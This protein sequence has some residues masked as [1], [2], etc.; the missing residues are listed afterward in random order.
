MVKKSKFRLFFTVILILVLVSNFYINSLIVRA[1][2]EDNSYLRNITGTPDIYEDDNS[3]SSSKN[4][5]LNSEQERSISSVDD[6]D[7]VNFTLDSFYS[8]EIETTGLLGDTRLWIFDSNYNQIGFDDDGGT[9]KF[10]KLSFGLFKAGIYYIK[11]DEFGNDNEIDNYNLTLTAALIVDPFEN[12]DV[13]ANYVPIELNYDYTRSIH[14]IG[15]WEYFG[16]TITDTFNVTLE[17]T[18]PNGDT[19]MS[20]F[21]D[22]ADEI[23]SQIAYD[24]DGGTVTGFSKIE[25][26][27]LVEG[28]Y[29]VKVWD[30]GDNS[31]ILDYTL[32]TTGTSDYV[33]DAEGPSITVFD[34]FPSTGSSSGIILT[35]EATDIS[36]TDSVHLHYK[37]NDNSWQTLDMIHDLVAYY[38]ICVGPFQ[39]G[40]NFT[41]Y[42]TAYDSSI[43]NYMT[44]DNNSSSN[45][46]FIVTSNDPLDPLEKDDSLSYM[47]SIEINSTIDRRIYPIGDTDFCTFEILEN[48]DVEIETSGLSGDTVLWLY[49]E[50]GSLLLV[51][52]NSG[53]D[54]FSKIITSLNAG[55]YYIRITENGDD[56]VISEYSLTLTVY[57]IPEIPEFFVYLNLAFIVSFMISILLL[58]KTQKKVKRRK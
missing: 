22:P 9:N 54:Y 17:T 23:G 15:D 38:G 12:D 8:I 30:Y 43:Y 33:S 53:V 26:T 46:N 51:N 49:D 20:V 42:V 19:E 57:E 3:F 14:P 56:E 44:T 48:Y 28:S 39:V 16:F 36:G 1:Y 45:Y 34:P 21:T 40:D 7:Y 6:V 47:G 4:I 10:S 24:D 58:Q 41:Y 25:L 18:G 52:D 32:L 11:I 2:N 5:A 50:N 29:Y 35:A 27:N 37:L 55:N 13:P 31:A